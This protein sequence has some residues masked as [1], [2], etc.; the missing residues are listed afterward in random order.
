MFLHSNAN[1]IC[2]SNP[3]QHILLNSDDRMVSEYF[4]YF[5]VFPIH[6]IAARL[7]I[8]THPQAILGI[9]ALVMNE[10]IYL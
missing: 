1:V 9:L 2:I 10:F 7:Y 3:N 5:L 4:A 6:K 8:V